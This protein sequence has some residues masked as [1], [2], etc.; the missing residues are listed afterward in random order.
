[1][2]EDVLKQEG[3]LPRQCIS[4]RPV[5]ERSV[6]EDDGIRVSTA[7]LSMT[8]ARTIIS[9]HPGRS[10]VSDDGGGDGDDFQATAAALFSLSTEA[11]PKDQIIDLLAQFARSRKV[12]RAQV[13]ADMAAANDAIELRAAA[14]IEVEAS[15]TG[16]ENDDEECGVEH[17]REDRRQ[18][19]NGL[20]AMLATEANR[21]RFNQI[22]D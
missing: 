9:D 20:N 7:A 15:K 4:D 3:M 12:A 11:E 14:R 10:D 8:I 17:D 6:E 21:A 22:I 19:M 13:V 18:R 1:M 2:V 5:R 16:R